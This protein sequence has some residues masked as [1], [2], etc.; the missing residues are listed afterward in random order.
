VTQKS[1][2]ALIGALALAAGTIAWLLSRPAG[3]GAEAPATPAIAAAAF[4]STSFMD[5]EG[6]PQALGQFQGRLLVLNFW[7][8]WCGPCRE[9]MP[10]FTRV[11]ARWKDRGVRFLGVSA[12]DS[13][14]VNQFGRD[15]G[16][17]Y[18]LWTGG[19][20]VN[21]LS[22][23][24]GNRLGVLPHTVIVAPGGEILET[25]VGPYTEAELEQRLTAYAVKRS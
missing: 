2:F 12:E 3:I 13:A 5:A 24:L 22:R 16:V 8:T 6:R 15:L 11:H 21:E 18:P 14:K 19:D 20:Q 17:S 23:R 10:A 1:F 9:E 7:A 25:R 4:Y